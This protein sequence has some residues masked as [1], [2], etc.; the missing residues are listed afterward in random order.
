MANSRN[1]V[2][3]FNQT[4]SR[5]RLELDSKVQ[6]T[7]DNILENK[8]FRVKMHENIIKIGS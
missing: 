1:T 7:K 5:F 2:F 4:K 8:C 3:L 6:T